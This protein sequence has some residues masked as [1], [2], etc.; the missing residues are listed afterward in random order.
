MES[1]TVNGILVLFG[2]VYD[3]KNNPVLVALEL[4][5]TDRGGKSLNVIKVASAYGKEKNLQNFINKSKILYVEPNK[6]RTHNW[7]TVNRLKLPLPSTK[8][9][10]FNN[11]IS[12]NSKNVNTKNDESSNDIKYSIGYTTDNN[13]VVVINDDILKGVKK[14][15]WVKTVKNTI[16]DKFS[17]GIPIK[18]RFIKVNRI[19]RNEYTNSNLSIQSSITPVFSR[20]IAY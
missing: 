9:G 8:Y 14:S 20:H 17:N 5:P 11:S 2:D 4:N 1:N 6:K 18:G 15:D 12:Q 3:S 13:P 19:T 7:L 16:S 10:F